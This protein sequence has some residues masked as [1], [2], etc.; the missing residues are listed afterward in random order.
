[1]AQKAKPQVTSER[2]SAISYE[3]EPGRKESCQEGTVGCFVQAESLVNQEGRGG[4]SSRG[5]E[6]PE[7]CILTA[8]H[9]FDSSTTGP[10]AR[11]KTGKIYI[12]PSSRPTLIATRSKGVFGGH[13]IIRNG[14][15]KKVG[16]DAAFVP[17]Q[18]SS[19]PISDGFTPLL[20]HHEQNL[21]N[22]IVEKKGYVTGTTEGIV[23]ETDFVIN[24]AGQLGGECLLVKVRE[25]GG[26]SIFGDK[27]DSG[28][29]VIHRCH[30]D[31]IEAIG[32]LS[33]KLEEWQTPDEVHHDIAIIVLLKNCFDALQSKYGKILKLDS[34]WERSKISPIFC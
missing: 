31:R 28:S 29:L 34:N 32:I 12:N 22:Q 7:V 21:Y 33:Q 10:L 16:V 18:T 1:M 30:D 27:G 14:K 6:V 2:G 26:F 15:Q 20:L 5:G 19:P 8:Q 11:E 9:I 25:N 17:I 13:V 24:F 4:R 3:P 23:V